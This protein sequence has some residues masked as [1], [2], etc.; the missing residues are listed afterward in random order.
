MTREPVTIVTYDWVPDFP[1][2]YVRDIRARWACEEAGIPY[3]TE[4][5]PLMDRTQDHLAMQPFHQVPIL[6]DGDLTLFESGAMVLHLAKDSPALMPDDDT[7]RTHVT[8]WS[9]AALNS[10]E[11]PIT[12]WIFGGKFKKNEKAGEDFGGWMHQRLDQLDAYLADKEWIVGDRFTAADIILT[13]VLRPARDEGAL[14]RH[15]TTKAYVERATARPAFQRAHQ[16]QMD[17]WTE[18]DR[19]RAAKT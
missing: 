9:F 8:E 10:I 17:H 5:V 14:D 2:G 18:A 3:R 15:P 16:A 11:P 1:R 12:G 7:L 6:K 13:E 19:K 4:T